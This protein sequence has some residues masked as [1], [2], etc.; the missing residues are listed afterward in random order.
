MINSDFKVLSTQNVKYSS[1][2]DNTIY[3]MINWGTRIN[4]EIRL[5]TSRI[6]FNILAYR[7]YWE[8]E[9]VSKTKFRKDYI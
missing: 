3:M 5:G 1:I 7:D 6:P 8:Y 4:G 9:L 2:R